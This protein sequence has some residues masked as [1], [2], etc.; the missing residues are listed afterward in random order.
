MSESGQNLEDLPVLWQLQVSH[1]VEKVRW[2]LDY[3]RVAHIRRSMLPGAHI[4]ETMR[5]T[6]DTSTAPVL[7][8]DRRSIGDS[9]RII[10]AI[11]QRW[12]QPPLYPDDPGCGGARSS[13][14]SSSTRSSDRTSGVRSIS[15]C[16]RVRTCWCR[17]LRTAIRSR[18][19]PC[20]RLCPRCVRG[21]NRDSRSRRDRR[22]EPR[23]DGRGDGSA[24]A[25]AL[26][27]WVSRR[28]LLYR[29]R[30]HRCR[31]GLSG[32]ATSGVPVLDG[33]RR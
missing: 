7:T 20:V 6:G 11:E 32:G 10:A 1:Y 2:A 18:R 13:S 21:S 22:G 14:R 24:R 31:L 26:A 15:R 4:R 16:S 23:E 29:R 9:T 28:R 8:I 3:K 30:P 12:P 33:R 17:Y 27:E 5:L 19:G 25:R